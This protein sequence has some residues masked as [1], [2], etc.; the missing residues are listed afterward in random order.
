MKT[1][2]LASANK[3]KVV[4]IKNIL[5]GYNILSLSDIGFTED[6]AETGTTLQENAKIKAEAILNFCIEKAYDYAVI[7]D[8]SGCFVEALNGEPGIYSARYSG[9]HNDEA[10]RQKMLTNL[11]GKENR[12]AYF[13][14]VIC[15]AYKNIREFFIGRT[16][17]TITEEK[18]GSDAFGYDCLF[19][20]KDLKKTF[21][22]AT[23]T[24]KNSVSHRGRAIEKLRLWLDENLE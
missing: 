14:C 20:S 6:I 9:D 2:V 21:G 24:E 23:E 22:E 1:I 3:H 10:N 15:L 7:S 12:E 5:S 13:E 18:R 8:D 4:E 16:Y 19:L 11:K 17:G